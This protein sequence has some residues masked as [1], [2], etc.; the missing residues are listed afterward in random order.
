MTIVILD[1]G[2]EYSYHKVFETAW[3]LTAK[4]PTTQTWASVL[5]TTCCETANHHTASIP[6]RSCRVG[7]C[8]RTTRCICAAVWPH[9]RPVHHLWFSWWTRQRGKKRLS[10]LLSSSIRYGIASL[11]SQYLMAIVGKP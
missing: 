3:G 4:A 2:A 11:S 9:M 8:S 5:S 10:S 1:G 7:I 6:S